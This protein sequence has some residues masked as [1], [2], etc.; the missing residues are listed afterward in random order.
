[1]K[2]LVSS[3]LTWPARPYVLW[4]DPKPHP[5]E[6]ELAQSSDRIMLGE[7][8]SVIGSNHAW[9]AV[10]SEYPCEL[11]PGLVNCSGL[12]PFEAEDEA[13]VQIHH[14]QWIAVFPRP[15]A[16]SE[17]AFEVSCPDQIGLTRLGERGVKVGPLCVAVSLSVL[18]DE[19][20]SLQDLT[21]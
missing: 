7:R 6:G 15:S 18:V 11:P 21:N 17:L 14:R 2:S 13:G 5:P 3:V 8:N 19:P 10:L 9:Q 20:I 4:L 12:E 1:M 16:E